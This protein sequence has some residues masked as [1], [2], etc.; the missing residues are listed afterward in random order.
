MPNL[1]K[2]V[3]LRVVTRIHK[4]GTLNLRSDIERVPYIGPYLADSIRSSIGC[5]RRHLTVNRLF[6]YLRPR[7]RAPEAERHEFIFRLNMLFQNDRSNTCV[8]D[9]FIRDVNM[10]GLYGI[11]FT[12]HELLRKPRLFRPQTLTP[13][14]ARR[15]QEYCVQ[16]IERVT[17][18]LSAQTLTGRTIYPAAYCPCQRTQANCEAEEYDD[19]LPVCYWDGEACAPVDD[20]RDIKIQGF[21]GIH[22]YS[23]QAKRRSNRRTYGSYMSTDWNIRPERQWRILNPNEDYLYPH[24]SLPY[25]NN[26]SKLPV[27]RNIRDDISYYHDRGL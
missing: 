22:P 5:Q 16:A 24:D 17:I 15:F 12:L 4:N 14:V 6:N 21:E 18:R 8:N 7:N 1:K 13:N 10:G 3:W 9:Y 2:K 19:D 26:F 23:G 11:A 20:W 27:L 25:R